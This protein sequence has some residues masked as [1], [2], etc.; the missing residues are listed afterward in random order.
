MEIKMVSLTELKP[1]ERNPRKNKKAIDAVAESIK[2][3]G[4][5][6]PIVLD[7]DKVIVGGHTRYAA[8]KKLGLTEVPCVIADD[9]TDEQVKAFRLADNQVAEFST[10]DEEKLAVEL[11]MLGLDMSKY[12][13]GIE[14]ALAVSEEINVDD[15]DDDKFDYTCPCCG[16]RFNK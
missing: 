8:A 14:K 15:F 7:K 1:Y 11:E 4:F 3:F 12:G 10:W 9:L 5:K 16:F 6:V 13:F 2:E